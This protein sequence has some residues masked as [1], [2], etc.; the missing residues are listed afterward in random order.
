MKISILEL[1][2]D[3]PYI[4][5]AVAMVIYVVVASSE[6]SIRYLRNLKTERGGLSRS[7]KVMKVSL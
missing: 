3:S 4:W 1:P 5:N 2:I 6:T 7:E